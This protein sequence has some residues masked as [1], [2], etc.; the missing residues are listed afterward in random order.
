MSSNVFYPVKHLE[1]D[2]FVQTVV[3]QQHSEMINVDSM[4]M[5]KWE[6]QDWLL[7]H[8]VIDWGDS[9]KYN[10]GKATILAMNVESANMMSFVLYKTC[11]TIC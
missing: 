11:R 2:N 8:S 5:V 3:L 4:D 1:I 6:E 7:E 9:I 10:I